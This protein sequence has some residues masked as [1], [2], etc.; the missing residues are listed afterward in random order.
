[1]TFGV[2]T[3]NSGKEDITIIGWYLGFF[4][5]SNVPEDVIYLS[6]K[7]GIHSPENG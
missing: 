3:I 4:H 2:F 6:P 1:M 7:M 5:L